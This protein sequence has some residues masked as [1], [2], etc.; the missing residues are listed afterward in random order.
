[1]NGFSQ[2][3]SSELPSG[4]WEHGVFDY[5][6]LKKSFIPTYNRYWDESSKVPYL[7]SSSTG[8]WISYDDLESIQ[9]KNNYIKENKLGGAFFW[10][11]SSDRQ[12]QLIN[13]TFNSLNN[14][15]SPPP[16]TTNRPDK[17]SLWKVNIQ[18]KVDQ[19]VTYKG[20]IYRC[21]KKHK[22]KRGKTPNL[23][24]SFWQLET[25]TTLVTTTTT[26]K[27]TTQENISEWKSYKSYLVNDQVT[28]QG[29]TYR[30]RQ[31]HTSLSDWMPPAVP[32]LWLQV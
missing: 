30:C 16:S 10:E 23:Q 29:N 27:S 11:L 5:D 15:I 3:T 26:T 13:A 8:I 17:I 20:K 1:M 25:Q 9:I 32:A 21:I 4:T 2:T 14:R 24:V 6:H 12:A 22:S 19:R 28:Y 7:F 18:Y 31:S